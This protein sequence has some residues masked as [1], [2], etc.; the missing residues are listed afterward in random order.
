[1]LKSFSL[2][3]E[4]LKAVESEILENVRSDVGLIPEIGR[5][6][7]FSGG[8]RFRPALL[9]LSAR[10]LK[11]RTRDHIPLAGVIELIH[12]ATLLHDDVVDSSDLRR[13]VDSANSRWGNQASILVGDFLFSQAFSTMVKVGDLR[14]M[15]ILSEATKKM[16]EGEVFQ[17][18]LGNSIDIKE[19][20]YMRLIHN[21]TAVLIASACQIGALIGGA[22]AD[23]EEKFKEFGEGVGMAFQLVDDVFDYSADTRE[24]GKPVGKDLAEKK[25]TLPLIS[26][27]RNLNSRDEKR[28]R[29][30]FDSNNKTEEEFLFVSEL[31]AENGGID[32]AME[33]AEGFIEEAKGQLRDFPESEEKDA[34][35]ELADYVVNRTA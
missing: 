5:H 20:D 4:E 9:I 29:A 31:I 3:Q 35:F 10:L 12:T 26:S 14:V 13:G 17:L 24:I 8:K 16:S 15:D 32:Y 7:L 6:L 11:T 18:S 19:S 28:L 30:I 33:K 22:S 21:K 2:I 23:T 27:L 34:L 25:A 1:M